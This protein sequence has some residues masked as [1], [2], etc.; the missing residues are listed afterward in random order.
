MSANRNRSRSRNRSGDRNKGRARNSQKNKFTIKMQK[1]L[2]VLF[3]LV[4]L[5]FIGLSW[6]L[7][8]ITKDNGEK[9]KKQVL[10]QQKYDSKP[11]P[12]KRGEILDTKGTALAVSEKVYNVI[13]DIK[14]ML[15]K[16]D[17]L[18]PT[19]SALVS[20]FGFEE[21]KLRNY[22]A[23]HPT[24]QY[25]VLA[26]RLPYSDISG[27]TELMEDKE[28]NPNITGVW[29]EEEYKRSYPNGS[30]ACDVIGFTSNDNVGTYGL[31]EYYNDTLNG[32]PGRVYGYLSEDSTFERTTKAAVDGNTIVTTIDAN[33]QGIVEKYIREFN[34]AHTDE[35]REGPGSN[36]TGCIVMDVDSGEVLAMA[37]YPNYDL[38]N[39]RDISAYYSQEQLKQMEEEDT[40]YETLNS[41]W[42]NFCI[43]DTYEPGSTAKPFTVAMGLE[44]GVMTGNETYLCEGFRKIGGHTIK[45][46]QT[47]GD[48]LITVKEAVAKSCNV[49]LMYMGEQIGPQTFSEYQNTFNF[50]LKTN[51]D[52]AGEARTVGLLYTAEELGPSELA[53]YTFGQGF[54][55]SMIQLIT[56]FCSLV[57]GGYYYEPHVVKKIISPTGATVENIEPRVLKQTIS[58]STSEKI[59]EYCNSVVTDGTGHT[60]RPA[61][62]AIGG[63]TG[64][65]QTLPR[66][67][68]EYVVSFIG[69]APADDPQIVIYVVVDRANKKPQDDAKYATGIVR[70]VLSEI[71]P[72][73]GIYM[74][75]ELSEEEIA[76]LKEKQL[77][78]TTKYAPEETVSGNEGEEPEVSSE[79]EEP[80]EEDP[81]DQWKSFPI[82]PNTGYRVDPDTNAIYDENGT[83]LDA[84][85]FI[86]DEKGNPV[87]E[88]ATTEESSG[89]DT[90]E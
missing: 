82:D 60:A 1:K 39:P 59:I 83:Q 78:I 40:L 67:N 84:G 43:S 25:Y 46:H 56:G 66:G 2:V 20:E 15:E 61:G 69:Y 29:F 36:N 8:K 51:I 23:E 22:I 5:A 81:R 89:E 79:T 42:K 26:K 73:L 32:T 16:K 58:R 3:G 47:F 30:L 68:G 74:T 7:Y 27:F 52:L 6:N 75:E 71:L 45:C 35:V 14:L 63:K 77:E 88:V 90:P 48:G 18:E 33:I 80:T 54:N 11:L 17:A 21:G 19:V 31:E 37:S 70:N 53:T 12:F 49:A 24:S 28:N 64:T 13:L 57:N 9:Y 38:N 50:G 34:E 44:T 85:A 65:A 76:E 87:N 41:I 72:Y 4:L 62:Y 86:T 55:V 10:S